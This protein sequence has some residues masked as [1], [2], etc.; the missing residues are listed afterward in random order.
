V[1][2]FKVQHQQY[3]EGTEKNYENIIQIIRSPKGESYTKLK[4]M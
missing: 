1:A 4:K 2:Y 3:S